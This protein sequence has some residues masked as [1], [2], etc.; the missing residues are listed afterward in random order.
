MGVMNQLSI[1][2]PGEVDLESFWARLR[3][4]RPVEAPAPAPKAEPNPAQLD[5]AETGTNMAFRFSFQVPKF[6]RTGKLA[7]FH[8]EHKVVSNLISK[9]DFVDLYKYSTD[10]LIADK[11]VGGYFVE[12]SRKALAKRFGLTDE[13]ASFMRYT[14]YS[15]CYHRPC[16]RVEMNDPR[17]V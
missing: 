16:T 7:G 4:P 15:T 2:F 8:L 5:I 12:A 14:G 3:G 1:L 17:W 9:E 10:K 6:S 11:S 13:Q